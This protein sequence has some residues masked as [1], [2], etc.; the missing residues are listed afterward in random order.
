MDSCGTVRL[1]HAVGEICGQQSYAVVETG[2]GCDRLAEVR[3]RR[4]IS[5]TDPAKVTVATVWPT[6]VP[7]VCPIAFEN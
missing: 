7:I 1:H 2:A 5:Q 3:H 6:T 4:V